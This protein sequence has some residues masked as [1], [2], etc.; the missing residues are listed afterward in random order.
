[1]AGRS[2]RRPPGFTVAAGAFY[3]CMAGVHLGIVSADPQMYATF[4]DA[5]PWGWLRSGWQQ[6]FMSHPVLWGLVTAALELLLGV[7][8]LIGDRPARLGWIGIIA[9]QLALIPFGWH[10]LVWS[11]PATVLLVLGARHDWPSLGSRT[12]G[13]AT[14]PG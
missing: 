10:M 13:R 7:L 6:V 5:S 11:V 9:F 4:A 2:S 14:H 12:S 8:L 1:M 3:A